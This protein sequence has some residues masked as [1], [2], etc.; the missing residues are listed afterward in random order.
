LD[1]LAVVFG[2]VLVLAGARFWFQ[3]AGWRLAMPAAQR[4]TWRELFGAVVAGEAAGYFAWGAVSREP[5]KALLVGHRL[6]ERAALR[7]AVVGRFFYSVAAAGV[8]VA[9]GALA[10]GRDPFV[11]AV[12]P[13]P[14]GPDL[15]R[16]AAHRR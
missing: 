1:V 4:P 9:A 14:P 5:M 13:G 3:A 8:V 15:A 7:A 12:L 16:F 10:A 11:G 6:P 2:F